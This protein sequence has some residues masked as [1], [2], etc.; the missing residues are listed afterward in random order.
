M[1]LFSLALLIQATII[2]GDSRF[3]DIFINKMNEGRFFSYFKNKIYHFN[4]NNIIYI[5]FLLIL[6]LKFLYV[7]VSSYL[8][9]LLSVP[10]FFRNLFVFVCSLHNY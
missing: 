1:S 7:Q 2:I 9:F 8:F 4:I 3:K 10:V 6:H 5:F